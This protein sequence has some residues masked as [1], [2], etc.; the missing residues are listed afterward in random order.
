MHE[1]HVHKFSNA[2]TGE[3][4]SF[5]LQKDGM[6][7]ERKLKTKKKSKWENESRLNYISNYALVLNYYFF[8]F[9]SLLI[10]YSKFCWTSDD[11]FINS[12]L[13]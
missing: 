6:E 1:P 10:P 9:V 12:W 3:E 8:L 7:I 4:L 2:N 13:S 11:C 5:Y